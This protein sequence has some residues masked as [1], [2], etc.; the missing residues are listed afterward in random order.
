MENNREAKKRFIIVAVIIDKV[1]NIENS[2]AELDELIRVDGGDVVCH[3][4]QNLK[5]INYNY[6]IGPGKIYELKSL[7]EQTG[8]DCIACDDELSNRQ[9]KN[10]TK[11]LGIRVMD[12]TMIILNIFDK[13]AKTKEGSLQVELAK[14]RYN[15]GHNIREDSHITRGS[16]GIRGGVGETKGELT[17]RRTHRRI[18]DIER[19]LKSLAVRKKSQID[20]RKDRQQPVI[21]LVGYTNAGKTTLMEALTNSDIKGEDQLFSTLDTKASRLKLSLGM[22]VI[23]TDT[24]GFIRKI[25]TSLVSAFK[26]TLDELKDSDILIHVVDASDRDREEK[27]KIVMDTLNQLKILPKPIITAL[28]KSELCNDCKDIKGDM[29]VSVSAS[30]GYGLDRLKVKLKEVI[31]ALKIKI[32]VV[33]PYNKSDVLARVHKESEILREE[34]IEEGVYVEAYVNSGVEDILKWYKKDPNV[35]C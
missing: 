12:R 2:I 24:I 25:P 8:V 29:I 6:Y 4:T 3:L 33:I 20:K 35:E 14:L 28:N 21:A 22:E 32:E 1:R 27:I 19:E 9:I 23:M 34:F 15:M 30:N 10:L 31:R 16:V 26:T 5:E 13:H 11:E 7:I 18:F 17:R